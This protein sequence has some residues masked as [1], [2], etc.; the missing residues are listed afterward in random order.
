MEKKK[1]GANAFSI[2]QKRN[3][4]CCRC[5]DED[6]QGVHDRGEKSGSESC[7]W[8]Q[9]P[10]P[11]SLCVNTVSAVSSEPVRFILWS[12]ETL[13]QFAD[14][15]PLEGGICDYKKTWLIITNRRLPKGVWMSADISPC[16]SSRGPF[17]WPSD[18]TI[19]SL[20]HV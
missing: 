20:F 2:C 12:S 9:Q 13:C 8:D 6:Q 4:C 15:V 14:S 18:Q 1:S 3:V 7:R 11:R 19:C 5:V 17:C 10:R 16:F